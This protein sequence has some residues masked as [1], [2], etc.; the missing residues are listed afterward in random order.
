[1]NKFEQKPKNNIRRRDFLKGIMGLLTASIINTPK[2]VHGDEKND[3][4]INIED[5]LETYNEKEIQEIQ[6]QYEKEGKIPDPLTI[7]KHYL[8]K[9]YHLLQPEKR[10]Y[11]KLLTRVVSV[12]R[13]SK[14][15][16][17]FDGR[18]NHDKDK[19]SKIF[20]DK[21]DEVVAMI[22]LKLLMEKSLKKVNEQDML[23]NKEYGN[24]ADLFLNSRQTCNNS[25]VLLTILAM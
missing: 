14:S 19:I 13:D 21:P 11:K 8:I 3:H 16:E 12:I 18:E 5:K 10:Q 15:L 23:Y 4:I 9:D 24:T 20:N 17:D 22:R 6:K 1:M 2:N 7:F 25:S